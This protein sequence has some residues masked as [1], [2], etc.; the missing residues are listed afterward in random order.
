MNTKGTVLIY[1]LMLGVVCFVLGM[2]LANPMRE[3]IQEARDTDELNCSNPSITQTDE[4]VCTSLDIMTPT[5]TGIIFGLAGMILGA[6][7]LR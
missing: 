6:A 3:T 5:F 7:F 4:A 2:A 1:A